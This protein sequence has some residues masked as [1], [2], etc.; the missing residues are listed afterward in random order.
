MR[1]NVNI[2]LATKI[3]VDFFYQ[4]ICELQNKT[5]DYE[6]FKTIFFDNLSS[7][8]NLYLILEQEN[9]EIGIS[10]AGFPT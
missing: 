6:K 3:D 7:I 9:E 10:L 8:N 1:P 5:F 4:S 2:R